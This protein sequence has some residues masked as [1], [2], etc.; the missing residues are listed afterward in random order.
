MLTN[1]VKKPAATTRVPHIVVGIYHAMG[2]RR[3]TVDQIFMNIS[4]LINVLV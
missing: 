3:S 2:P 1:N 4:S